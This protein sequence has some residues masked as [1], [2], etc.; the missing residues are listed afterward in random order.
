MAVFVVD[1][2]G[3]GKPDY[4]KE[5]SLGQVRPGIS[6]KFQQS[7]KQFFYT[8][9]DQVAVPYLIPWVQDEL[10]A[11]DSHR[12]YDGDTGAIL[13]YTVPQGF[14]LTVIEQRFNFNQD[15]EMWLYFDTLLVASPA[16]CLA[17]T[18]SDQ[19]NV[20]GYST[21]TLDPTAS[22]AHVVDPIIWNRG[23]ADMKGGISIIAILEAVGT[24]PL[25][26]TKNTV[27]PFCGH[28]NTVKNNV[29]RIT[30]GKCSQEYI[31][32]ASSEFKRS[33]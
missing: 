12:L 1:E 28:V 20:L 9:Q 2:R 27:C 25:P 6:I 13:P 31:V 10:A 21:L 23:G 32:F 16:L 15:I 5:I 14:A 18:M 22:S 33:A 8:P 30:C 4:S 19:Q 11:G 17:G 26:T 3:I 7:L 29:T 24:P